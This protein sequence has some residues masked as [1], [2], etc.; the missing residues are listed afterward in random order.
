MSI[1]LQKEQ[2]GIGKKSYLK[3][4]TRSIIIYHLLILKP[5][6]QRITSTF[7]IYIKK[8]K[9]K[10]QKKKNPQNN[11]IIGIEDPGLHGLSNLVS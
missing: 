11:H 5:T 9:K 10:N 3:R 7:H 8:G 1:A 6:N 2:Y 4:I